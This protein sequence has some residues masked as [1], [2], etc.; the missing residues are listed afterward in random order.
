MINLGNVNLFVF[1]LYKCAQ[2]KTQTTCNY[3]APHWKHTEAPIKHQ[4]VN[5]V[6]GFDEDLFGE[7]RQ[8]HQ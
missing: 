3:L 1:I 2:L 6:I 4:S 8:R 5:V 7:L